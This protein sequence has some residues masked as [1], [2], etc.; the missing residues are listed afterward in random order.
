MNTRTTIALVALALLGL[1]ASVGAGDKDHPAPGK[2][3]GV[4]VVKDIAYSAD[5]DADPE[6]HK[7]N[8]YLPRDAKGFPVL[9]YVHGGGWTKGDRKSFARQAETLAKNGVGVASV[10]YRLSPAV[11]HPVHIQDVA[12]AFAWVHAHIAKYGGRP[13][14][15]FIGGHSAGGHLAA[16]LATDESYLK[17]QK[18]SLKDVRGAVPISGVYTIPPGKLAA[19]FGDEPSGRS[20]ASP[21]SHVK[22]GDPPFLVLYA[23]KDG[24]GM[25]RMAEEFTKALKQA[26][27]EATVMR[28]PDRNH[29]TI[30]GN[31]V[32]PDDPVTQAVLQF[33][34]RH[35]GGTGKDKSGS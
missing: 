29:G 11:K 27:N 34:R 23:D 14:A 21:L 12:S 19:V 3:H 31:A 16:L 33:I 13:D 10:G 30:I 15:L 22:P 4:E 35:S 6:R 5:K 1:G 32:N 8:L 26:G 18:L 9:V 7:L 2:G 20:Q 25:D 17:A 24:P 28:I